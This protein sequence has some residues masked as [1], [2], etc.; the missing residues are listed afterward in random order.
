MCFIKLNSIKAVTATQ[1]TRPNEQIHCSLTYLDSLPQSWK[2]G[3]GWLHSRGRKGGGWLHSPGRKGGDDSTV[4]EGRVGG[5]S[6][7]GGSLL[8]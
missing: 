4:V 2:E 6:L 3:W 1:S 8:H 5:G 7:Y